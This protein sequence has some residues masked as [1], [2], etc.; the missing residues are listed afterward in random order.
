MKQ[1]RLAEHIGNID[2]RLIFEA[3]RVQNHRRGH[4]KG[5][6]RKVLTVAAVLALMI[7]SS[8]VGALA[9]S[10]ETVVEVP[11]AQETITFEEIG[12]TLILPDSW[13]GRYEVIEDTFVPYNSPMWEVCVKSVYDAKTPADESGEILYRGTLFYV[14]Q[15]AD[16]S[17]SA[18]EFAQDEGIAGIGRYLVS[19][20]HATY[21]ILYTTDVQFD[22][23]DPAQA[24]EFRALEQTRTEIQVVVDGAL[25]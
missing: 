5:V 12:L 10:R 20:E 17:M 13:E 18:E 3:D 1:E 25:G 2:G 8:V 15:Y 23:N 11:A 9:F 6:F 14:F 21:A 7:C 19:T 4:R 22:P 16:Y 24:E